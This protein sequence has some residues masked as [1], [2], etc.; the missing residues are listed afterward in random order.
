MHAEFIFSLIN[1]HFLIKEC[2]TFQ[3][4]QS[5]AESV[6]NLATADTGVMVTVDSADDRCISSH[7]TETPVLVHSSESGH[8]NTS[9]PIMEQPEEEALPSPAAMA[10]TP[11]LGSFLEQQ[12]NQQLLA[13]ARDSVRDAARC[14]ESSHGETP[15]CSSSSRSVTETN[16]D[17][18]Q[19]S[20]RASSKSDANKKCDASRSSPSNP[21]S[22]SV[23]NL[24]SSMEQ[25][26]SFLESF[27]AVARRNLG[28]NVNNMARSSNA[29][30]VRLALSSNP[31][32]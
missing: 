5:I 1:H 7:S 26:V 24:T 28:N 9:A 16:L 20:R 4:A 31:P 12:R 10:T 29:S 21:M 18:Q 32:G 22:V 8:S 27:A 23:P 2:S 19:A 30:L 11:P 3:T 13:R 14:A 15:L 25:T 6:L 17:N